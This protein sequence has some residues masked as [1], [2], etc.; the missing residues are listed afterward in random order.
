M[1]K[2]KKKEIKRI[3]KGLSFR[4]GKPKRFVV[5]SL[6]DFDINQGQTFE[7][8]EQERILANLLTRLRQLSMFS[9]EEA[10]QRQIIKPYDAFPQNSEFCHPKHIP[11]G[12]RWATIRIKG[13]ERIA[14]YIDENVFYIVFLDKDHKFWISKKKHT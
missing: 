4:T 14:G 3:R 10:I 12:V 7:K 8:W 6:K 2:R 13:K 5:F 9:V 11:E 1:T